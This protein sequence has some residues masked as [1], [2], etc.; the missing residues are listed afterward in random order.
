MDI[1][2][3]KPLRG[4]GYGR[5]LPLVVALNAPMY[6]LAGVFVYMQKNDNQSAT[7]QAALWA[8]NLISIIGL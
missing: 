6:F 7:E 5:L 8:N 2:N 3:Y 4:W 1:K